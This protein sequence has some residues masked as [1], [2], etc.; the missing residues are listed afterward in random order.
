M[1]VPTILATVSGKTITMIRPKNVPLPTEVSPTTKP[2]VAP[3]ATAI[4][5][6]RFVS[7]KGAS[8]GWTP[9]RM[10]VFATS[11]RPPI[12]SAIPTA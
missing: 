4:T 7:R 11:P 1:S 2:Q 6:S 8:S 10:N 9:M 3:S 12:T 5:R